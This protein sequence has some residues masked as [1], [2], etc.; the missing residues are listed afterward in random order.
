MQRNPLLILL[1]LAA[2][3]LLMLLPIG[4]IAPHRFANDWLRSIAMGI[5]FGSGFASVSAAATWSALGPFRL[6]VRLPCAL[7]WALMTGLLAMYHIITSSGGSSHATVEGMVLAA[8]FLVL[9]LV[10]QTPLWIARAIYHFRIDVPLES[11]SGDALPEHQF[12]I[13]QLLIVTAI[14]AAALGAG[15]LLVLGIDS[16]MNQ[17]R[18][19]APDWELLVVLGL[20]LVCNSLVAFLVVT[21]A[22]LPKRSGLGVA[23]STAVVVA[24]SVVEG[25]M[26][27]MLVPGGPPDS[28][29]MLAFIGTMNVSQ[30]GW[31]LVSLLLLRAAGY[32]LVRA[33]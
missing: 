31:L 32:K 26:I 9:G 23:I 17:T 27:K 3:Q 16:R 7:C 18:I 33:Q 6:V 1:L 2:V 14:I 28:W 24:I 11:I 12:G 21:G 19:E 15:R 8:T 13:R 20:F 10:V 4:F 25:A 30:F 5:F 29:H 22:L